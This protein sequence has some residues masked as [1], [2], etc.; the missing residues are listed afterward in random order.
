MYIVDKFFKLLPLYI[1][2]FIE[3]VCPP[4]LE[5]SVSLFSLIILF[6]LSFVFV[7]Y[8]L[9]FTGRKLVSTIWKLGGKN[10]SKIGNWRLDSLQLIILLIEVI[11]AR[12][13]SH[14]CSTTVGDEV[15]WHAT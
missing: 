8:Y 2:F 14:V 5:L 7:N 3:V 12:W 15:T 11:F 4:L 1:K 9:F 10:R 6:S 13:M